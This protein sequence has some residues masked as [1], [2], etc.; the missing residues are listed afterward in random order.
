MDDDD[1]GVDVSAV[2][3][4]VSGRWTTSAMVETL[5]VSVGVEDGRAEMGSRSGA[6]GEV[7]EG[8]RGCKF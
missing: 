1:V 8:G 2:P 7:D 5:V 6:T 4:D 3:L